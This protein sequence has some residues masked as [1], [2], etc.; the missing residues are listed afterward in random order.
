MC[1][2]M[3]TV[4]KIRNT[5]VSVQAPPSKAHSLRA[6]VISSLAAGEST[7]RRPLLA[8]DQLNLIECL[9]NLGI[10]VSRRDDCL[11]VQGNAGRYSPVAEQL[12]VGES[13]VSMNF[14]LSACCLCERPVIITG[15]ER[16][17]QRPVDEL[18]KGLRQLGCRID[19][20]GREGFPPV[21]VYGGGIPGG[22]AVMSG[23]KT[24]QYF[25][26]MTIA[27]P[28][29]D[30]AVTITCV[31]EMTERPYLDITVE[32][33][34]LFGVQAN[35]E[36]YRKITVANDVKYAPADVTIEGDYSS[37]SFFFLAAA[38]CGC[39]VTVGGLNPE[40]KQGDKEFLTLI[41]K[42]GCVVEQLQDA[43][44]VRGGPLKAI[45]Q[46]MGD[47][48]DLVPPAAIAAA[49]AAGT[50]RFTNIAHLRHKESD[51][52]AVIASELAKMGVDARCQQDSLTIR[53]GA[54][55]HGADIDPHN[56]HRI[57]MSFAVA[58]L[59]TGNQRIH[60]EMC[61]AKSFPDFWERF[62]VFTA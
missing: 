7:I 16:I 31:D 52:P 2:P 32:M 42:M 51:R 8:Q 25:S 47:L 43:V 48:P 4:D 46:D 58:G 18:V 1:T 29:A 27:A 14:L 38:V 24:S 10:K 53:G 9:K 57:A 13:G 33:M 36:N 28:C 15:A 49:F 6:L 5:K 21:R 54:D 34:S 62:E 37:A 23:K 44:R 12:N 40:T 45:E 22:E 41:R 50:S 61:V 20:L 60:N 30:D 17:T 35:N 19:Y 3:K 39:E 55:M 11:I 56:D 59:A 26:S